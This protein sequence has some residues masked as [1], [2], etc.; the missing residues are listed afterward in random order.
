MS[1]L[2]IALVGCLAMSGCTGALAGGT[3]NTDPVGYAY[4]TVTVVDSRYFDSRM[5]MAGASVSVISR[6]KTPPTLPEPVLSGTDGIAHLV[7]PTTGDPRVWVA[8][9]H[10]G[11]A[12]LEAQYL[13][14]RAGHKYVVTVPMTPWP[15]GE[16][17]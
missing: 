3:F 4:I 6:E 17:R 8:V 10:P 5:P 11:F 1:R 9:K 12:A 16:R 13:D 15:E 14:L 2:A 7:V